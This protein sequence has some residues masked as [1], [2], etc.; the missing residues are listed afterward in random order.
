MKL[1]RTV[2]FPCNFSISPRMADNNDD[3]PAPTG[4]TTAVSEPSVIFTVILQLQAKS[5]SS[6]LPVNNPEQ[7]NRLMKLI[8][9]HEKRVVSPQTS[10][11]SEKK[12]TV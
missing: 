10:K 12:H 8:N 7:C 4:P 1:T 11:I 9:R 3:L 5:D 2:T 6:H